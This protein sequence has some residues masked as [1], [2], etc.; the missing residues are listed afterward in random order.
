MCILLFLQT[1][2]VIPG[3][4][5]LVPGETRDPLRRLHDGS[6]L[7]AMLPHRLAGMTVWGGPNTQKPP[8]FSDGYDPGAVRE[9]GEMYTP[10]VTVV[11]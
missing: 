1:K 3:D 4:P 2:L 6:R 11:K 5:G 9:L 10:T 7:G 8:L